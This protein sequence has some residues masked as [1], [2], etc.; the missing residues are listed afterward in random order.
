[1]TCDP[2]YRVRK[3][4]L[5]LA[6]SDLLEFWGVPE[7]TQE[8]LDAK[9]YLRIFP[10]FSDV[11][12]PNFVGGEGPTYQFLAGAVSY[13][14]AAQQFRA[15]VTVTDGRES[16]FSALEDLVLRSQGSGNQAQ[17]PLTVLDFAFPTNADKKAARLASTEAYT[18]RYGLVKNLLQAG[19]L[20][21]APGGEQ[22]VKGGFSFDFEEARLRAGV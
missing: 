22:F 8:T 17:I 1:M 9:T 21:G 4:W 11:P 14:A 12:Q 19:S 7:D 13:K 18:V 15:K 10:G 16:I 2:Q 20:V 3:R 6:P 5:I